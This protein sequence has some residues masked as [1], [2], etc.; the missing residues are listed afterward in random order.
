M[1][2]DAVRVLLVDDSPTVRAVLQ[3]ILRRTPDL[4]VVG[5]AG[6]GETGVRLAVELAPDLVLMDLAMPKLDGFEATARIM[7]RAPTAVMVFS[8]EVSVDGHRVFEA[9]SRGARDVLAKPG[10]P[11]DWTELAS[12]L[13]ERIRSVAHGFAGGTPAEAAPAPG[14][15]SGGTPASAVD[16]PPAGDAGPEVDARAQPLRYLAIGASTGGPEALRELLA[17]LAPRPPLAVLVVQHIAPE[18]EEGLAEWLRADVKLDV[19]V[20]RQG[21]T[22]RAGTVR[23]APQGYHLT[24]EEGNWLRLDADTPPLRG[25]RPAADLLLSSCAR[26]AGSQT[27]G[28]LLS[29]MGRDGVEGLGKL[30]DAGG[31]TLVQDRASSVVYGMPRAALDARAAATALPPAALG[32]YL[33]KACGATRR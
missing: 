4:Q 7:Q 19:R 6:D 30:K 33:L 3:R 25:H 31:L 16:L 11:Q 22:P 27:A 20:A 26:V 12:T 32:R 15:R 9:Y 23:L 8:T 13:P 17:E 28:V 1:R 24:L 14:T 29:G 5:E 2:R 10:S 21:E 18:F